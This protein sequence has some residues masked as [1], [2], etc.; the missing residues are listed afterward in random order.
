MSDREQM[1]PPVPQP[2]QVPEPNQP[3][4]WR[5]PL[6]HLLWTGSVL[7]VLMLVILGLL[8]YFSSDAFENIVRKRLVARLE[9]ATGGRVEIASFRWHLLRLEAEADGIVI[10]GLEAPG[11]APYAKVQT[12]RADV[13]ILGIWSPR[14]L[15]RK[16]EI[17]Q[18]QIHLIVYPDGSTNQPHPHAHASTT[19]HPLDSFFDLQAGHVSVEQG[20]LD[21]ENRA[22]D[23]DFQNRRIPLDFAANEFS[24]RLAYVP[25]NGKNPES[26]HV[27][28]SAHDLRLLRGSASHPTAPPVQGYLE[29]T[30]DLTRN[31]AYLRSLRLTAYS[32]GAT[33]HVLN[34]SGQLTDFSRPHW[35]AV[36]RGEL[37]LRLMEPITG[38]PFTPE[39]IARID[40]AGQGFDGQFGADG[41][42]HAEGAAYVGPGVNARGV[43][44]DAHI[45]ADPERLLIT[46]VVARL[47][48]GGQLEGE[49][50]LDRWIPPVPGA[51][52][53]QAAAP[54]AKRTKNS[55]AQPRVSPPVPTPDQSVDLH[56]NGKVKALLKNVS[57]DTILDIVGQQ[58]FQRLGIN[59][60]LNGLSTAVWTDGDVE[61]LAVSANLGISASGRSVPGESPANG[62]I[63]A[64]YSQ[65]DGAVALRK[66]EVDLPA[67]RI[68][69]HGHLGAYP[70]SSPSSIAIDFQSHDLGEFDPLLRDLGLT[71]NGK[72][73]AA[74]LS[75]SLGGNSDFH[76][77][78]SGSVM[79]P[80]IAGN[81]QATNLS[82]EVPPGSN[83][84][85]GP[86]QSFLWDS[87]EASGSYSAARI[88]IDHSQLRHGAESLD[89]DGTLTAAGA[90]KAGVP[91]FD[92]NS[93]LHAH[94]RT[95]NVDVY[96]LQSLLHQSLPLT[97]TLS[98]QIDADGPLRMLNGN[99]WVQLDNGVIYGEPVARVRAEGKMVDDVVQIAS[100]TLNEAAGKVAASGTYDLHSRH[101]QVDARGEGID[102][103]KVKRIRDANLQIDGNLGFSVTGSGTFDDPRL[104]G[105][106]SLT[107]LT[108][109]GEP[110]G[111]VD[112]V[113]HTAHRNLTYD[114]TSRLEAA[115]LT[116]HGRT[117]LSGDYATEATLD[118]SRFNIGSLLR[119]EHVSGISGES[120]IA[121][122]VTLQGPLAKPE[123]LRGEARLQELAVSIAGVHLRSDGDVHAT[124]ADGRISL[125][126]LHVTGEE[127]DLHLQGSLSLK[128]KRQLDL[129]A[130]GSINLKLAE[131]IDPDLT[132][133]GTSTFRVEAHGTLQNPS[134]TGRVDFQNASLALEDLPN[135]LSQLHGTLEF[136]QDRLEVKSL[137]A[138]SGGGLLSVSGYLAYRN[139]IYADLSLTGKGIRIRYPQGVSS[140]ADINL[141]LQGP[142]NN[143]LLH[144]GVLITR[145]TISPEVDFVALA[146]QAGKAQP[147]ARSDAP[148]N[149]IRLDVRVQSSPQLNF[150]NAYAKLAGDVDL[151][152]RGT[153]ASPS[154]LGRVSITEGSATIAG[155]R[156]ELQRG[157][158]TFTNPVRIQPDIDLNATA[159]VEDYDITLGLHGSIDQLAVSYRSNPPLPEADVV[160]L[161]ALGRT[162]DQQRLYTQQQQQLASNPA[163]DALLGGALNATVSSRVQRLF[164]AGSVKVDPSYLGALGNSTT[165]I[166]VE[167]QLGKNLTLT[168][169]TDVDTTAQQL[170]QAEIAINRHVSLLV[171]RDESGVFSMVLK[172]TRRFR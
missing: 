146:A 94:L 154:L 118:F 142:Q 102:I 44:L 108:L 15:L 55:K 50:L 54:P 33:D 163:T 35:Q 66:L 1:P 125:D 72:T 77:T 67:S 141:Q 25:E 116:A 69:A 155:T 165:R 113:A 45:H 26:Y 100:V 153:L 138:M 82:I 107:D 31:A 83:E 34:I 140:A 87:L 57:L 56:T 157:E 47:R 162:Q 41:S 110:F 40:L 112:I 136:N 139:G 49:V 68:E 170:L 84:A 14:I 75:I 10:H 6:R 79:D 60:L 97:G 71:R 74:A 4:K 132:A 24:L 127:T 18:P 90:A 3:R 9:I 42:V 93:L 159:R 63:D 143:L 115:E 38:Y 151:H 5:R 114:I 80:H 86:P 101:F 91:A 17:I 99:G 89:V 16:L 52:V 70:L 119:L 156:Y 150:Q 39:G 168:Y 135:S 48:Q 106:A 144:G 96:D 128:D 59:A 32:K 43:G 78:W 160:A 129:A 103:A 145:F 171:A 122:R 161:L 76:G 134:L 133:S 37:D 130:N 21:D 27:Q 147:L 158:I 2:D 62:A 73:G 19:S 7:T 149:H 111:R 166:T 124:L 95:V 164:G 13:D 30:L 105:R 64:T 53:I 23:F 120:A 131:T 11:E 12:L 117:E 92:S 172:A 169:A 29:A 152:V 61:T 28:T 137:T 8:L 46:S 36:A 81:I 123:Q 20:M 85:S 22:A 109:S 65:R 58:P 104:E 167:E 121:G 51:A 148:S 126:P 88:S 98:A